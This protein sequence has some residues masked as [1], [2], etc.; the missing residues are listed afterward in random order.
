MA[1]SAGRWDIVRP[2]KP[3][4]MEEWLELIFQEQPVMC[5]ETFRRAA[6][7]LAG[8]PYLPGFSQAGAARSDAGEAARGC[9]VRHELS[10]R[11]GASAASGNTQARC[12]A[13]YFVEGMSGAQFIRK[14][15]Y[16]GV[17]AALKAP[18]DG[19]ILAER[20]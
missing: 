19:I 9:P 14:E 20:R 7:G 1:L 12:A 18:E 4:K 3:K 2:L 6:A 16:E 15:E 17:T 13:G 8:S 10:E 11:Y 5:R